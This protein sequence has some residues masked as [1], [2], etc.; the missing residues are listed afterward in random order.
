VERRV[1]L[2]QSLCRISNVLGVLGRIQDFTEGASIIG[3]PKVVPRRCVRGNPPPEN[4]E[5][6]VLGNAIFNVLRPSHGVLRSHFIQA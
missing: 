3:P 1:G 6:Q 4:F 2:M 5:I